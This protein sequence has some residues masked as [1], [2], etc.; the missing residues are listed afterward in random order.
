MTLFD[1]PTRDVEEE[2]NSL[3]IDWQA[4]Q[5]GLNKMWAPLF[6]ETKQ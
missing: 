5:V 1:L 2:A 3:E 4:L 6:K